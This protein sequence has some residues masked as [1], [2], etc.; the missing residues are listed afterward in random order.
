MRYLLV[1]WLALGPVAVHAQSPVRQTEADAYTRYELLAPESGKFKIIYEVTA[2]AAGATHYFNPI[3][4]GSVASDDSTPKPIGCGCGNPAN[5]SANV[6]DRDTLNEAASVPLSGSPADVSASSRNSAG[7]AAR[8]SADA[9]GT[10]ASF[11]S[12]C[13]R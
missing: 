13:R 10:C 6:F 2:T 12:D 1:G 3:R 8:S 9:D 11:L 7:A 5:L 4:M